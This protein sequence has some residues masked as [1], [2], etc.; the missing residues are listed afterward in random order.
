MK[1]HLDEEGK[2]E[3]ERAF[4]RNRRENH[5]IIEFEIR[6]FET[7]RIEKERERDSQRERERLSERKRVQMN[8]SLR[9]TN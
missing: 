3:R 2:R 5:M 8:D 7:L 4:Q 1:T 9:E 6:E